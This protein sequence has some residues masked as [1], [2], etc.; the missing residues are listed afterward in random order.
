MKKIIIPVDFSETSLNAARFSAELLKDRNDVHII[1]YSMFK[2]DEESEVTGNYLESLK[3]E[4]LAKGD[5][6]IE[7]IKEEGDDLIDCL[8]RLVIQ[9]SA[10]MIIMGITDKSDIKQVLIGS[11]TLKMVDRNI[12]PVLIIPPDASYTGIK[13]VALACDF[14]NIDTIPVESIKTILSMFRPLLH[15]VNVDSEHYV[16]L[17]DQYL[18]GR[19]RM[20]EFFGEMNPEFY[21]I[22]MYDFQDAI[23]QFTKDRNIDMIIT[24]PRFHSFF[25][26]L[27]KGS[28]TKKLAFHSEVP[29]LAVHE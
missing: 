29:V 6:S 9:K 4:L 18:E 12:C 5:C 25:D 22:G 15:I 27:F 10:T 19:K 24:I 17:S 26:A 14:K 7:W 3:N 1:L 16:S 23:E 8:D 11:N 20:M 13:N 21:F 2:D 28:Q